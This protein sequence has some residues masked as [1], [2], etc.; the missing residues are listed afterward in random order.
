[1]CSDILCLVQNIGAVQLT[2]VT[3]KLY[4]LEPWLVLRLKSNLWNKNDQQLIQT[5]KN[6][7]FLIHEI[8][9][10]RKKS[11]FLSYQ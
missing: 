10:K 6:I 3:N 1:M 4:L 8:K 7:I 11:G 9:H 5:E 2:R